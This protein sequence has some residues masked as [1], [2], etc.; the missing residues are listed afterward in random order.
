MCI[1]II[2]GAAD[3]KLPFYTEGGSFYMNGTTR[4]LATV[5]EED[6]GRTRNVCNKTGYESVALIPIRVEGRILGL[7]HVADPR[8]NMVPLESVEAL[9]GA[10][11]QLG[12]A[13]RRVRAEQALNQSEARYRELFSV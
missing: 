13:M 5:S 10:A 9:E 2:N 3:P 11:I 4:F 7:V 12:T 6:K 8:E 1:N